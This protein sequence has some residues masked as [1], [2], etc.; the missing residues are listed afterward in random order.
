MR[1][2]TH[3]HSRFLSV[4]GIDTGKTQKRTF[5]SLLHSR[6][7]GCPFIVIDCFDKPWLIETVND[8]EWAALQTAMQKA[9]K[10]ALLCLAG[11]DSWDAQKAGM[12]MG[13]VAHSSYH[14]GAIRQIA[15]YVRANG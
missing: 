10:S 8:D 15:K 1:N 7:Q 11:V 2:E 3:R 5:V 14:L 9:Y 6:L 13:L 12:A 4:P